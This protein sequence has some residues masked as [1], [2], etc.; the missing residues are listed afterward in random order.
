M[1]LQIGAAG[2]PGVVRLDRRIDL[3]F[4]LTALPLYA[5]NVGVLA[6]PLAAALIGL[7]L[8]YLSGP[9]FAPVAG[10][11]DPVIQFI[12][13]VIYGFA[14]ALAIIFAGD[15]WRHGRGNLSAAWSEGRRKAGQIFVA[16]IGFLFLT[17]IA[18]AI[19]GLGGAYLS[20]ALGAL[21]LW[22]FIYAVP[23]ASIGGVPGGA[24]FS[25]SLQAARRSPIATA[26]LTI[27]CLA[28]YYY[29]GMV[30]PERIAPYLGAGYDIARV[31]LSAFASGYVALIVSRQYNDLAFRPFW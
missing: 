18:Q 23:A 3:T 27:V 2:S 28:V 19:G 17:Y 11:G 1:Q 4:Y 24:A 22:A 8:Q 6:F 15:A 13:N 7:G 9:L 21:A 12:I 26:I 14:L 10:A 5:R 16:V 30:L 31:L 25:A 20:A 29:V